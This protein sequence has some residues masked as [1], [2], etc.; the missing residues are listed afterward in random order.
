MCGRAEL[1]PAIK[2]IPFLFFGELSIN[3]LPNVS[4]DILGLRSF[5]KLQKMQRL[6]ALI[7][8]IVLFYQFYLIK[9]FIV[10]EDIVVKVLLLQILDW[11]HC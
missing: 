6:F 8:S 4:D 10:L 9:S 5:L 2:C 7:H 11:I 1:L 3:F